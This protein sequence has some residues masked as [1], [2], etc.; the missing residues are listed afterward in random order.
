M[1]KRILAVVSVLVLLALLFVSWLI[2]SAHFQIR[3][4]RPALPTVGA[5]R[6]A[7][8]AV[9][10]GPVRLRWINTSSQASPRAAALGSADPN[11]ELPYRLCHSSFVLEWADGRTLL[12]DAGMTR[13][14]AEKFGALGQWVGAEPAEIITTVGETLG[15]NN[16]RIDGLMFTHLHVDHIE[17]ARELC[18]L[19]GDNRLPV[20]MTGNQRNE[21]NLHTSQGLRTLE[22]LKC[23]DLREL[24]DQALAPVAGF[25]GLFVIQAS[26]HTPGS[27]VIVAALR[28]EGRNT[29]VV[30]TG[31]TVIQIDGVTH[32][33]S[34]P[35]LYSA[36]IVPE[37]DER[38]GE[39]RRFLRSLRDESEFELLVSH[40]QYALEA[41]SIFEY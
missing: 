22:A 9:S 6:S 5:V 31:D 38:L 2:G 30:F 25:P 16:Q 27:Q 12:I 23:L 1:L 19:V 18:P 14:E 15:S 37:D 4:I 35:A 29:P 8:D 13:P 39:V 41:S 24:A 26:G 36:L 34:K 11:P 32:D 40:D 10:D 20:F 21:Q 3:R 33:V 17:G 28:T 7:V